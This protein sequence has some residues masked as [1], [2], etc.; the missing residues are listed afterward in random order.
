M[1][2]SSQIFLPPTVTAARVVNVTVVD[3]FGQSMTTLDGWLVDGQCSA[4]LQAVSAIEV[5]AHAQLLISLI[6]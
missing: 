5:Y 2:N 1:Q 3:V 4:C 6:I